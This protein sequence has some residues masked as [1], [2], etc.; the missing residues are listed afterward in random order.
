MN[1]VYI[2]PVIISVFLLLVD[3][4]VYQGYKVLI[5][6]QSPLVQRNLKI[7]Y[8][9]VTLLSLILVW[10]S[11]GRSDEKRNLS[12]IARSVIMVQ[13]VPKF[14]SLIFLLLDDLIRLIRWISGFFSKTAQEVIEKTGG[15]PRSEFLMTAGA[16]TAAT[17]IG[18]FTF[19]ILKGAHDYRIR[20]R[21]IVQLSDIHSGSFWNKRA[22]IGGVEMV[23]AEKPEVILFTGDLVNDTAGEMRDYQP[24]FEKLS[25]PLGVYSVLGNHDYG[26]YVPWNS[27]EQKAQNLRDLATVQK[28]MGWDLLINEHR[29]LKVDNEMLD[30]VGI[31]NWGAK[32]RFPKYGKMDVAMK[33][34]QDDVPK[35]LLSH[36]PSHWRAQVLKEYPQ[37]GLTLAG[38]THGMQFGVEIPG[39]KW[40]PVQ[41]MYPEWADLYQEGDQQLY[42]NRGFGYI[43][44]P[45]RLGITPEITVIELAAG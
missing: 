42:V 36:D 22:V 15:V 44:F 7:A 4:Y 37:V 12:T 40:S 11:G 24:V 13:Y 20:R 23:M 10:L 17:L 35:I 27:I 18:G 31:E 6:G 14:L 2:I 5:S 8:W 39:V 41:Y 32:G 26:D 45:G 33:G 38:H 30:I 28:N 1:K 19:G 3:L 16:V 21:T 43:G 34:T 9:V 29:T 25:A